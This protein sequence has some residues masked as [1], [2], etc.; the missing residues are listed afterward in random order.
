MT[1]EK[2]ITEALIHAKI[3]R[4]SRQG[5]I[6]RWADNKVKRVR[7]ALVYVIDRLEEEEAKKETKK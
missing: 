3:L 2:L 6:R 4:N 1:R 5:N 7:K